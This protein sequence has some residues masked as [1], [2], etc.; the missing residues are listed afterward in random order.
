MK[1]G[2]VMVAGNCGYMAGFMAQ[3]G[4]MIVCGDTGKAFADSMYA[5][6]CYVGGTIGDLGTDAVEEPIEEEDIR[7]LGS[8]LKEHLSL[9]LGKSSPDP[10][11]FK[12]VVAGRRLWKFDKKDW[13]I[14]QE[15]L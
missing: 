9:H 15:A 12:K 14:W 3:K 2:L 4:T 6:T 10:A 11:R 8:A 7:F 5:T 1:G 13:T